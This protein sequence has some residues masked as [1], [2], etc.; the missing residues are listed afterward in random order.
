MGP[1]GPLFSYEAAAAQEE[2]VLKMATQPSL[3]LSP[4]LRL[5]HALAHAH[6]R[7]RTRTRTHSHMHTHARTQPLTHSLT[8]PRPVTEMICFCLGRRRFFAFQ[9]FEMFMLA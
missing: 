6:T 3:M 8:H 7:T 2:A 9:R 5:T 4:A 1:Q